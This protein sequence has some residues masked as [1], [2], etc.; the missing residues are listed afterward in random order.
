ML[1]FEHIAGKTFSSSSSLKRNR[2]YTQHVFVEA[3]SGQ[4]PGFHQT[5]LTDRRAVSESTADEPT[6]GPWSD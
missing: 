1:L 6:D 3:T 5:S 2:C 4:T